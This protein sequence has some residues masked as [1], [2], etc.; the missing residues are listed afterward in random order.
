MFLVSCQ[1]IIHVI[2]IVKE[3]LLNL[4]AYIFNNEIAISFLEIIA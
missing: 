4:P 2:F 3:I 1:T